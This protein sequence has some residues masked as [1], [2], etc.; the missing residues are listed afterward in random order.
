MGPMGSNHIVLEGGGHAGAIPTVRVKDICSKNSRPGEA[1]C[2][3]RGGRPVKDERHP[4]TLFLAAAG[5]GGAAPETP[6]LKEHGNKTPLY[7]LLKKR[8]GIRHGV[9]LLTNH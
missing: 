7:P 1:E 9:R 2:E 4:T 6:H 5:R 8:T 3:L